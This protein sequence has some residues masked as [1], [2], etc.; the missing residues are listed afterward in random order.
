MNDLPDSLKL[1]KISIP[2]THD[3]ATL[4]GCPSIGAGYCVTQHMKIPEQLSAGIR[5]FDIRLKQ[6]STD[7]KKF[8]IYHGRAYLDITL[9]EVLEIPEVQSTAKL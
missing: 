9:K 8:Y 5:F 4:H 7:K 6:D 2:G 1:S 3:S